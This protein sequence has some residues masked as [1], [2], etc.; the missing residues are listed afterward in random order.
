MTTYNWTGA[1]G[2]KNWNTAGNWLGGSAPTSDVA[3][4]IINLM[5]GSTSIET[6]PSSA[7]DALS[8]NIGEGFGGAATGVTLGTDSVNF[9]FGTVTT[10]RINNRRMKFAKLGCTSFTT[11]YLDALGGC[12]LYFPSGNVVTCY[13]GGEG[14]VTFED[15][16][17]LTT[18]Y[19]HGAFVIKGDASAPLD[20]VLDIGRGGNGECWRRI[21]TATIAGNLTMANAGE[22]VAGAGTSRWTVTSGGKLYLNQS[23]GVANII[24][25][26]GAVVDGSKNPGFA[27]KPTITNLIYAPTASVVVPD[28]IFTVTNK[29]PSGAGA[30]V[31]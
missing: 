3:N 4:T 12:D 1:T 29:I 5:L 8:L 27:T 11:V 17:E 14:R 2:D 25:Q 16:V 22:G 24:A 7:I 19:R 10:L 13:G 30:L 31:A 9:T 26:T 28:A 21:H 23:G 15:D 6:G 20:L 18:F